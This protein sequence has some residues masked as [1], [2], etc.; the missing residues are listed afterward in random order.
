M[1]PDKTGLL[2]DVLVLD[3]ADEQG[4]FCSKLLADLGATVIKLEPPGGDPARKRH[5]CSFFYSNTNKLGFSLDLHTLEGKKNFR[6]LVKRADILIE[7]ARPSEH[8]SPVTR[9]GIRRINPRLVHL[10]ITPFGH[11]GPRRDYRSSDSV[12]S[13]T[14]GQMYVTGTRTGP[15]VNLI[16][17]QSYCAASLFGAVGALIHLRK[18]KL[19]G[20]GSYIDLSIQEAVA[21]TLDHVLVDYFHDGKIARRGEHDRSEGFSVLPSSDGFV[22]IPILRNWDTLLELMAAE[23]KVGN[24]LDGEWQAPSCR[25]E[26]FDRLISTVEEWTRRHT[27]RELFELG[28]AMRFPW[29]S[30]DSIEEVLNSPQLEARNFFAHIPL[31]EAGPGVAVPGLPYKFSAFPATTPKPP[32][33][34]GEHTWEILEAIRSETAEKVSI[35]N[36]TDESI[37]K[38][39]RVLDLTRVLSGP[40]ATRILADYGAE[41]LKIQLGSERIDT[42]YFNAWNRNK[43]SVTLDLN[44]PE[45]R[46]AFLRLAAE[47]D[48]I[49]EN[50]SPRVMVNWGLD[51]ERLREVNPDL[52]MIS[53][54]AMGHTGPWKDFVGFA[55]TFHALSGLIAAGPESQEP[56]ADIGHA[57]GDVVAALYA[58]LA[59]FSALEYRDK[60]G[61]GMHVDL[62]AYEAMCTLLGPAFIEKQIL[63]LT[64]APQSRISNFEFRICQCAGDDRWCVISLDSEEEAQTLCGI[65]GLVELTEEGIAQWTAEQ[66]AESVVQRLQEAGIAAGVVQNAEDLAK[67]PQLTARRFFVSLNHPVLGRLI[68]D[69]SALWDWRC[70]P[71][72]WKVIRD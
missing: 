8:E 13:A 63:R 31:E 6:A 65:A 10:S 12:A 50:F 39:I 55:P 20:K 56:P 17:T 32:P 1:N 29:A 11:T 59:I 28:Q 27:K 60:T 33:R 70:R 19:T 51:Y 22:Q 43:R 37:L 18:R 25:E 44:T 15:P 58:A 30:V 3:L 52:V 7:T 42:A 2:K 35:G 49:V 57:Y 16:N 46:E 5:P 47:S 48:V 64:V 66:T 14:G 26:H 24:L 69:R 62:S 61:R 23:G 36:C 45:A 41:V 4:S 34:A 21:S 67:D 40:Y 68:S 54:S 38:G 9:Q 53:I 71:K 72:S